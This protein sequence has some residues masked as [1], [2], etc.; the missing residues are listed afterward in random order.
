MPTHVYPTLRYHDARAAID[1]L[2]RAFGFELV[3]AHE[4]EAG[5]IQHAEMRWGDSMI[6]VGEE[7]EEGVERH[8]AHAGRGWNYV[9]VEDPDAHF[10]RAREAGAEIVTELADLDYG[11]RDYAAL[12]PEGNHWNFGTYDPLA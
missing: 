6:I 4:D 3:A 5:T 1:F 2:E 11:S 12:D 9:T 7:T 10:A 8:G